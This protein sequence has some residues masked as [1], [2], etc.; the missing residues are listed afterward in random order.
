MR[1]VS[2]VRLPWPGTRGGGSPPPRRRVR[3]LP[4]PFPSASRAGSSER[5][6]RRGGRRVCPGG[7]I[8]GRRGLQRGGWRQ[9][10]PGTPGGGGEPAG[11]V[12]G[13]GAGGGGRG[14]A[15]GG[16]EPPRASRG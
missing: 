8:C 4:L 2:S 6:G 14:P 13:G 15:G 1:S 11:G 7:G 9:E 5:S 12:G 3:V 16:G 10:G